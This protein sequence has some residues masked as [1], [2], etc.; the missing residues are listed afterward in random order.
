MAGIINKIDATTVEITELPIK[1]WTQD[2]K[3]MLEEWVN[4]TDK[5]PATVKDYKEYHTDTTVHFV[6]QM[7]EKA[8]ADAE[9]DG[10]EK[11]FKLASQ[12]TTSNMVC[13]DM[14]GKIRKYSSAEEILEDFYPKRMEAYVVR[15]VS[16]HWLRFFSFGKGI[17]FKAAHPL[18]NIVHCR[19]IATSCG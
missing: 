1:K 14:N 7:T 17:R 16:T 2:Y 18:L 3:E 4:G 12:I 5:V 11:H 19:Y 13:F 9:K 6:V 8:L 10:L 15:K